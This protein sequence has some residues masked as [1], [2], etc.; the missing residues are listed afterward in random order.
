MSNINTLQA[1]VTPPKFKFPRRGKT[2][3]PKHTYRVYLGRR[4]GF[5]VFLVDDDLVNRRLD[6][7]F[8]M[9]GNHA[10]YAYEPRPDIW[11]A[12]SLGCEEQECT[13]QHEIVECRG[14]ENDGLTYNRAHDDCGLARETRMRSRNAQRVRRKRAQQSDVS[15][16][17]V[18]RQLPRE[19]VPIAQFYRQYVGRRGGKEVW[20]VDGPAIRHLLHR[21]FYGGAHAL[22]QSYVPDG[23]IWLDSAISCE[24][25]YYI[26]LMLKTELKWNALGVSWGQCYDAG[27]AT[28]LAERRRQD[29]LC[30]RYQKQLPPVAFGRRDRCPEQQ[31]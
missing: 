27:A 11:I 13:I 31:P 5:H 6:P 26:L 7:Q 23:E 21:D 30:R 24:A 12:A 17:P 14:M 22:R 15:V 20:I 10:R 25:M 28:V 2:S 3:V 1:Q 9:G 4:C 8:I 16:L 19:A 18:D 29:R